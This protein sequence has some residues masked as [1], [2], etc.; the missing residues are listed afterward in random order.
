MRAPPPRSM[1][2]L[3]LGCAGVLACL[4][5]SPTIAHHS[6]AMFDRTATRVFTGVVS[7]VEP[8]PDHLQIFFAPLTEQRDGVERDEQGKPVLWSLEMTGAAS[9]AKYGITVPGFAPGTV[10]SGALHPA[11][12]GGHAGFVYRTRDNLSVLFKCPERQRPPPG[13]HCDSVAGATL[14]GTDTQM[15]APS[16]GAGARNTER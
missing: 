12:D 3:T 14:H 10:F 15:P 13:K 6:Y 4:A 2:G 9:V 16:S 1:R 5:A 11:R 7:H 8:G